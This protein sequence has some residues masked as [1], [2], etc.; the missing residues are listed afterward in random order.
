MNKRVPSY[1]LF[2]FYIN[3]PVRDISLST[4]KQNPNTVNEVLF[5]FQLLNVAASIRL[6]I[7]R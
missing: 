7:I 5:F 4:H 6:Y 1:S 3:I 2:L